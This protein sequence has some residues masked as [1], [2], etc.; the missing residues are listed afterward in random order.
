VKTPPRVMGGKLLP[1][2]ETPS[3][4]SIPLVAAWNEGVL[5]TNAIIGEISPRFSIIVLLR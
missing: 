4:V 1:P 5:Y 3:Q 2:I